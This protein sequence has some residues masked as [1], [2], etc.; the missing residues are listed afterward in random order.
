MPRYR[1]SEAIYLSSERRLIA[2]G[3]TF[4]SDE[5][6]GRAWIALDAPAVA[7]TAA[8]GAAVGAAGRRLA[9]SPGK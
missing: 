9:G 6:P 4:A 2:E 3:E 8:A 1:A 7:V 5:I